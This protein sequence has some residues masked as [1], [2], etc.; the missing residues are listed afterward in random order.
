MLDLSWFTKTDF[1]LVDFAVW[2]IC[3][4]FKR[5]PSDINI[6]FVIFY[7]NVKILVTLP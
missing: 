3:Q 5:Y 1:F 2:N 4:N 7:Q 6:S